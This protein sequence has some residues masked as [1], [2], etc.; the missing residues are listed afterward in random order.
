MRHSGNQ[1][2]SVVI[3]V[4]FVAVLAGLLTVSML[5][6]LTADTEEV[7]NHLG[8]VRALAIAEAGL[9]AG[10]PATPL[11]VVVG[12]DPDGTVE[13]LRVATELRAAGLPV[14]A[15]LGR[16]RLGRQL[17]G[18]ARD[19]AHFAVILGDELT[20]GQV[21]LKDLKAGTQRAVP[22]A[23]LARELARAASSHRHG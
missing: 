8:S 22:L 10:P 4:A 14:H 21:Q 17:E 11:A 9:E 23:D 20:E 19:G 13:R 6:L 1:R 15:D 5:M 12:A 16:R 18:A 7:Q 2:G 3:V